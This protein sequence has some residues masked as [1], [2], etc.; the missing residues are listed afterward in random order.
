LSDFIG[1]KELSAL[2]GFTPKTMY[3]QHSTQRV[4]RTAA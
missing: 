2:T 3:F 1:V 4:P